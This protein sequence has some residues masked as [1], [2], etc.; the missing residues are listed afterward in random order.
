MPPSPRYTVRLPPAL[1][2][3]VQAHVQAGTPFA[4]LIRAALR[5]YLAGTLP[6]ADSA[7][8]LQ[9]I[10]AQLDALCQRIALLEQRA[11]TAPTPPGRAEPAPLPVVPTDA[12]TTPTLPAN[13]ILGK[14]CPK[15]HDWEGTGQSLLRLPSRVCLACDRERARATRQRGAPS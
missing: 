3:E 8:N 2:A 10:Q 12:D 13:R 1:D 4:V 6:P 15:G 7:D 9:T 14:L 5:A 11:D